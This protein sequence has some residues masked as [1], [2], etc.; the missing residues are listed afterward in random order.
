MSETVTPSAA[1]DAAMYQD[2]WFHA[3]CTI[4][5]RRVRGGGFDEPSV[6]PDVWLDHVRYARQHEQWVL[7]RLA[8]EYDG[9]AVSLA[10]RL[11]RHREPNDDLDQIARE[12][13]I[14]AIERFDPDRGT[15]FVALATPTIIGAV[16]RHVRDHGWLI[17]V[18]RDVH[19][20]AVV[21][22]AASD[23]L[24]NELGRFPSLSE[25]ADRLHMDTEE[26]LRAL[27]AVRAR[28]AI[29]I[30]AQDP[31]GRPVIDQLDVEDGRFRRAEDELAVA[32]AL[33]HLD[34]AERRLIRLYFFA[35]WSQARIADDLGVSQ[36]QVSRQLAAIL[37]RLRDR[38]G[39]R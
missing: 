23:R 5:R 3:A 2:D 1:A 4:P 18:P 31:Q 14:R 20:F 34:D 33:T 27:A 9:Y 6:R 24:A 22:P 10:R 21:E 16:R 36:M 30:E 38:V 15:P 25:L 12:A 19:D 13:L 37:R 7:D 32:A 8:A 39:P 11:Y 28:N 29:S 17:R 35:N 26:V